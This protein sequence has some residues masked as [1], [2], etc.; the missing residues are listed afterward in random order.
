MKARIGGEKAGFL[1]LDQQKSMMELMHLQ[2]QQQ[3]QIFMAVID[4]LVN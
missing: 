2:Q 1:Y 3:S 4:K